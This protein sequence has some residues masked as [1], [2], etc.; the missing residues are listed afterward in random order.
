MAPHRAL[1]QNGMNRVMWKLLAAVGGKF[2]ITNK[3]LETINTR[4]GIQ[5]DHNSTTDTFTLQ[6]HKVLQ[7]R[8]QSDII[9]IPD[10][11][12]GVN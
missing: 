10:S 8:P 3:D 2:T 6:L 1:N 9:K 5:I 4:V 11:I 12:S 7:P